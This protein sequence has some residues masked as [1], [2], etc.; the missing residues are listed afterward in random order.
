MWMQTF[1]RTEP[2]AVSYTHLDV[3]K[4]QALVI[5]QCLGLS[6]NLKLYVF[7]FFM[8]FAKKCRLRCSNVLAAFCLTVII[9]GVRIS[10]FQNNDFVR[11]RCSLNFVWV[12]NFYVS[13]RNSQ[14]EWRIKASFDAGSCL[15]RMWSET[16][17]YVMY[18]T[19]FVRPNNNDN[20]TTYC[21]YL[22]YINLTL[23]IIHMFIKQTKLLRRLIAIMMNILCP[24]QR[25]NFTP[26]SKMFYMVYFNFILLVDYVVCFLSGR[27]V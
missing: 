11:F 7:F 18:Q 16:C 6:M 27:K 22:G 17:W 1:H 10:W 5:L 15:L 2:K 24:V 14:I 23:L 8:L 26:I 13:E 9:F 19:T 12:G 20:V 3:Y 21:H 25:L 4:R